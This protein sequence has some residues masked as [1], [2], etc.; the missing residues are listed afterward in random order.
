MMHS[1]SPSDRALINRGMMLANQS[2]FDEA[3]AA[4]DEAIALRRGLPE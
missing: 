2:R 3:I 4:F 1:N